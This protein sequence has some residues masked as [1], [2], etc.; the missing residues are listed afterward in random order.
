ML[1]KSRWW[2]SNE[3]MALEASHGACMS[4]ACGLFEGPN[5]TEEQLA[6][7][8][9]AKRSLVGSCGS[10]ASVVH[11]SLWLCMN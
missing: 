1:A 4:A 11:V 7:V 6:L 3:E 2:T 8:P 9:A 10:S 5:P